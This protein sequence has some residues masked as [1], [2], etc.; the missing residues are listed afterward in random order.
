MTESRID[1]LYVEDHSIVREAIARFIDLQPNMKV[2][3]SAATGEEALALFRRDRPD[4]TLMDLQLPRMSGVEAIRSIRREDPEARI[5]VL[6]MYE[7]DEDIYRAL[8]AG[9]VTYLLKDTLS[10]DLI[11]VIR[12]VHAGMKPRR[13]EIE[14]RLAKRGA[15][16]SLTPREVEVLELLSQG[17]RDKEI[18]AVLG[19]ADG[20]A[21][22]HLKNI[23]GKLD[24]KDRTAAL[25]TALRRG[26][27]HIK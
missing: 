12:D 26:I 1:I 21:H 3:A 5:V 10:N 27:V 17:M 6:T 25:A 19:I 13:P 9:A 23:F 14:M 20:T 16:L 8:E 24:V 2:V 7:G 15:S 18:A 22:N 11:Q 4:V